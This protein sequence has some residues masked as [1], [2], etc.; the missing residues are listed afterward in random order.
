M[1]VKIFLANILLVF[2][3]G[4]SCSLAVASEGIRFDRETA[5]VE[6]GASLV[7]RAL[8]EGTGDIWWQS[9]D[10]SVADVVT[11]ADKLS[12]TVRGWKTGTAEISA[13]F[14]PAGSDRVHT[15]VCRVTVV[16]N[17]NPSKVAAIRMTPESTVLERGRS[18]SLIA[19][20]VPETASNRNVLWKSSNSLVAFVSS[21]GTVS[22]VASGHAVIS[23]T[24][25]D[26]GFVAECSVEVIGGSEVRVTG[27]TLSHGSTDVRI[28]DTLRIIAFVSPE[29]ATNKRVRW[30]T[31]NWNI[32]SVSQTGIVVGIRYGKA[33]ISAIT[34]DGGYIAECLVEVRDSWFDFGNGCAIRASSPFALLLLLPLV[35]FFFRRR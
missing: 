13:H 9:S 4:A 5:G 11:G 19:T 8:T 26:G 6:V 15:A 12:V 32:A 7:L 21:Q 23:A 14:S 29:Y 35:P 34:E 33:V 10:N 20:V 22:G 31:S 30:V 24:S 16:P 27:I 3:M 1:R 28:D 2:L 17:S 18:V 25:V